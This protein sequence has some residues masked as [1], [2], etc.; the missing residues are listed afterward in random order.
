MRR[1]G[2]SPRAARAPRAARP[3]VAARRQ[4][5]DDAFMLRD[6]KDRV[7]RLG[8]VPINPNEIMRRWIRFPKRLWGQLASEEFL[9]AVEDFVQRHGSVDGIV[10]RMERLGLG[11]VV[12]SWLDSNV[13]E[14]IWS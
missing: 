11:S 5:Y 8:A 14:S 6:S 2:M 12:R 7:A 3:H 10:G 13:Y 1:T 4:T 9:L